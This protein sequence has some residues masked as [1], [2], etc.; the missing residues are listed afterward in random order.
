MEQLLLC[1]GKS[2]TVLV[3]CWLVRCFDAVLLMVAGSPE[4]IGRIFIIVINVYYSLF[5]CGNRQETL[6]GQK[7]KHIKLEDD[8][9]QADC[10]LN[11]QFVPEIFHINLC[12]ATKI[13]IIV[14]SCRI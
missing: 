12:S 8:N 4:V 9:Q 14:I 2:G 13:R 11:S 5:L 6:T 10:H 3:E 1:D 7:V